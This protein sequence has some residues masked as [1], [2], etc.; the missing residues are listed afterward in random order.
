MSIFK[1]IHE[2]GGPSEREN[3]AF[4]KLFE[5]LNEKGIISEFKKAMVNYDDWSC[6]LCDYENFRYELVV[7]SS[8]DWFGGASA[9]ISVYLLDMGQHYF[10]YRNIDP[11]RVE[12]EIKRVIKEFVCFND[13]H[14]QPREMVRND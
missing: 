12:E 9:Y 8:D 13:N 2:I 10:T 7:S 1:I 5:H 14:G 6:T 4:L 3:Y 11:M